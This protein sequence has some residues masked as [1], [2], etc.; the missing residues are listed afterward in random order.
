MW[1]VSAS[2]SVTQ[3]VRGGVYMCKRLQDDGR[4]QGRR[5]RK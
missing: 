4:G 2:L 3:G 1:G 5:Q